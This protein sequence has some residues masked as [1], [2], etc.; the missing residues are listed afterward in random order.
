M[1]YKKVHGKLRYYVAY[2]GNPRGKFKFTWKTFSPT[3]GMSGIVRYATDSRKKAIAYKAR[4]EK[5][6]RFYGGN[7]V[8]GGL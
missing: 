4:I 1:P 8:P 3:T 6:P 7:E 2:R 5:H